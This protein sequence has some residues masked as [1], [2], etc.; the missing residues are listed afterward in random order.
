[1]TGK[2]RESKNQALGFKGRADE[3]AKLMLVGH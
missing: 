2:G 1:M 3:V